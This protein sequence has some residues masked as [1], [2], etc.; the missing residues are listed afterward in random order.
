MSADAFKIM[1][2]SME[3]IVERYCFNYYVDIKM[4]M[5]KIIDKSLSFS[6]L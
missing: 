4:T 3:R 2:K 1:A 6:P 5:V